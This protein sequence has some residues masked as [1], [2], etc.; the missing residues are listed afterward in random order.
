[1]TPQAERFRNIVAGPDENINLAMAALL[2]AAEEYPGLD[3]ELYLARIGQL[4]GSLKQR[5]RA[6]ISP[7]DKII[8]LNRYLFGE[9]GFR[10][11]FENYYDPRNSFL[12]DVIDR[13]LGIPLTLAIIYIEIGR[14]IG[15]PLQGVSFPGHFLVKC[16]LRDGAVILDPYA[17][18]ASLGFDDLKMRIRHLDNSAEPSRSVIAGMLTSAGNRDILVRM[19]RNLKAIYTQQKAWLKALTIADLIICVMP[20]FAEE[21]RDRGM[22]YLNLECFRAALFDLQAYLKMHPS[23]QDADRVRRRM[24]ELQSV[25]ARL[26]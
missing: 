4:A 19:L 21:Y 23:A 10:G 11:N 20:D 15:L 7:A 13:K 9:L 25:A 26:N 12:N 18:G 3:V 24:V 6:D 16:T 14:R 17:R 22:F 5:L 8:L 2:I 1:M